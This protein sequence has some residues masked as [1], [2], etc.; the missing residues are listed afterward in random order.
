[1]E[2]NNSESGQ[3]PGLFQASPPSRQASGF[4]SV[5]FFS[6]SLSSLV[7]AESP[8][9]TGNESGRAKVNWTHCETLSRTAGQIQV[10]GGYEALVYADRRRSQVDG[11]RAYFECRNSPEFE[12]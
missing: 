10:Q 4:R 1:M 3:A 2:N 11:V 6:S 8:G 5:I 12:V 7:F 9:Q